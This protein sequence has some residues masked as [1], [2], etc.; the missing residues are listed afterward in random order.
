[1]Q[2]II[3]AIDA[4]NGQHFLEAGF[5]NFLITSDNMSVF[6][7]EDDMLNLFPNP[8]ANGVVN[9]QVND[10]SILLIHDLTGSL[11]FE[12]SVSRGMS[13]LDLSFLAS[14]SY[15]VSLHGDEKRSSILF[16]N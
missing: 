2:V 11:L 6:S 5:D 3:E 13:K 12:K 9:V 16:R 10:N 7:Y 14:G 1:M 8:S 15:I 4:S